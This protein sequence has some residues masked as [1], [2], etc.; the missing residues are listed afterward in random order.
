MGKMVSSMM[1]A[2]IAVLGFSVSAMADDCPVKIGSPSYMSDVIK[3]VNAAN[4]CYSASQVA[5]SCAMGSSGD[6]SIAGAARVKCEADFVKKAP[7]ADLATYQALLQKCTN[8]YKNMQG[9]MYIS[10]NAFCHLQV[11]ALFSELFTAA[12]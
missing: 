1:V 9:T 5:Q 11:A 8:K 10:M 2:A 7:K 6:G 12:E 3:A 4:G